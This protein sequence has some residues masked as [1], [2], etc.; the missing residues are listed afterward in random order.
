M[1]H[2]TVNEH[3]DALW[4]P[5]IHIRV[6]EKSW[7]LRVWASDGLAKCGLRNGSKHQRGQGLVTAATR[8]HAQTTR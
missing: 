8:R 3:V 1:F 7:K 5:A 6:R 2:L 4:V